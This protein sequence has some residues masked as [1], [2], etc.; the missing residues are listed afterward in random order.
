MST[1][2]N[3]TGSS[4]FEPVI[5]FSRAVRIG[6]HVHV[7]GTGPVDCEDADPAAQTE[8]CITLI[9]RALKEAGASLEDVVRTRI[10]LTSAAI[11]E[12][13]GRIHGRYFHLTPPASTMIVVKELLDARW[14]VEIEADA[15]IS[16]T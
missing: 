15:Y 4:P 3:I 16:S 8:Q 14:Q 12:E 13:V 10:Y 2:Q 1:R 5:G 6:Q 11:W 9:A 7:S